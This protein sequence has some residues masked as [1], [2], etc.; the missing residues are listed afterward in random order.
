MHRILALLVTT[1]QAPALHQQRNCLGGLGEKL[2]MV[3]DEPPQQALTGAVGVAGAVVAR[4]RRCHDRGCGC[5]PDGGERNRG[6]HTAGGHRCTAGDQHRGR[7][8]GGGRRTV[9]VHR[10][11]G[12]HRNA[13]GRRN[14][15]GRRSDGEHRS[16]GHQLGGGCG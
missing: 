1:S 5:G 11:A 4:L 9:I 16:H 14:V 3:H 10:S 6:L 12:G 7:R 2:Q 13:V 8:G 15:G